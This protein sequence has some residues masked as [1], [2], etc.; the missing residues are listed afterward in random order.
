M[1]TRKN[2]PF[3][4][5]EECHQ[6]FQSIKQALSH[7]TIL[8]YYDPERE[9]KLIVDGS[10]YGLSSM[11]P[12]LDPQLNRYR[13]LR[14]D[15]RATTEPEHRYSQIEIESAAVAF[16]MQR[17]HIYL[18][19]LPH[20]LVSTDHKPLLLLHNQYKA[21]L[22]AR[23][24]RDKLKLQEY[25]YTLVH[26]PGITNPADYLSRHP[27]RGTDLPTAQESLIANELIY[28]DA[29][30]RAALPAAVTKEKMI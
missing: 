1:L 6:A 23:I 25:N 15:S 3:H 10:K 21:E 4:W 13:I 26:E 9:T 18:H 20:F 27:V 30:V 24:L 7:D 8:A 5:T 17:N 16:G 2:F 29:V 12:Q 19:G 22:P 28:A 14:Y 11:L